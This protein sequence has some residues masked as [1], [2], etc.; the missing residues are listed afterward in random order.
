MSTL[1]LIIIGKG[2]VF[3]DGI[4]FTESFSSTSFAG[5]ILITYENTDITYAFTRW[6]GTNDTT[7]PSITLN[8]GTDQELIA[9]FAEAPTVVRRKYWP[10]QTELTDDSKPCQCGCFKVAKNYASA[11]ERARAIRFAAAGCGC[12]KR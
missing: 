6:G 9:N 11:E 12:C 10:S 7:Q 4:P 3:V 2:C 8:M 5:D 1:T